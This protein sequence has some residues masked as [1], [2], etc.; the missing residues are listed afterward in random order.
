M[1]KVKQRKIW[2]A[3]RIAAFIVAGGNRGEFNMDEQD[4]RKRS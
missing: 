2:S 1:M 4:K 3:A